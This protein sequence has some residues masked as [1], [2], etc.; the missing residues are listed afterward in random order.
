MPHHTP[1]LAAQQM[2]RS[3]RQKERAAASAF[4]SFRRLPAPPAPQPLDCGSGR[5]KPLHERAPEKARPRTG[6]AAAQIQAAGAGKDS[7]SPQLL[8]WPAPRS[9]RGLLPGSGGGDGKDRGRGL[10]AHS[11]LI[12]VYFLPECLLWCVKEKEQ[13]PSL[14]TMRDADSLSDSLTWSV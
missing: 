1:L 14:L 4:I 7:L 3:C 8:R 11:C 2:P 12:M 5:R 13:N 6:P 9:L 10:S